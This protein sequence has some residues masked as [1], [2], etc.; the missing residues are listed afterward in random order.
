[1]LFQ[2][3][4]VNPSTLSDDA[5]LPVKEFQTVAICFFSAPIIVLYHFAKNFCTIKAI[6]LLARACML[7]SCTRFIMFYRADFNDVIRLKLTEA[8]C[9]IQEHYE[10][11]RVSWRHSDVSRFV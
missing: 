10:T 11:R 4:A 5:S 1:V 2:T 6:G 8:I 3:V 7:N 9:A